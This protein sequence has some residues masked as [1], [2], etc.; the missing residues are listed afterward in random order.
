[1]FLSS[2]GT[3]PNFGAFK[4]PTIDNPGPCMYTL[5]K[6]EE[7]NQNLVQLVKFLKY[8]FSKKLTFFNFG[9]HIWYTFDQKAHKTARLKP[10][11]LILTSNNLSMAALALAYRLEGGR[12]RGSQWEEGAGSS[13]GLG[14][15][16]AN[17][18]R[19]CRVHFTE[20]NVQWQVYSKMVLKKDF[21]WKP[22]MGIQIQVCFNPLNPNPQFVL[23]QDIRKW[24]WIGL[25]SL[26]AFCL[27]VSWCL[28]I[29]FHKHDRAIWN[30]VTIHAGEKTVPN[31]LEIFSTNLT[32]QCPEQVFVPS[33]E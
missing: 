25:I 28:Q 24:S 1:M 22:K 18:H 13:H 33:H 29:Y 10:G 26:S 15:Y 5:K 31:F 11:Q 17:S 6:E 14:R 16:R 2:S 4:T 32:K 9:P 27:C 23:T 30:Y 21:C 3:Y 7:K 20:C 12:W 8:R 19:A